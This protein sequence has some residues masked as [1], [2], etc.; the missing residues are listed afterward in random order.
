MDTDSSQPL[1]PAL[2]T[3]SVHAGAYLAHDLLSAMPL[4]CTGTYT[5]IPGEYMWE[6]TARALQQAR[7]D[8]PY[9]RCDALTIFVHAH[10]SESLN[11]RCD[12]V[13][14]R[15]TAVATI[16]RD[17]V[18]RWKHA[19]IPIDEDDNVVGIARTVFA[20]GLP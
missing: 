8:G 7:P 9:P 14:V 5:G 20:A 1:R 6:R 13:V 12:V 16:V 10:E 11:F 15:G 4:V 17:G 19:P 3:V 2:T 18:P